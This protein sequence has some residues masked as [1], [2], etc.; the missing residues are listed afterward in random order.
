MSSIC[1]HLGSKAGG[2]AIFCRRRHECGKGFSVWPLHYW[3]CCC[4]VAKLYP[5]L[6]NPLDYSLPGSCVHGILQARILKQVAIPFFRAS[7]Q[8]RDWK[9][10]SCIAC[11][12]FTVKPPGKP[13]ICSNLCPLS[14]WCYL[15]ISSSAAR[16]PFAFNLTQ[17]QSFFQ[18]VGFLPQVAKVLELQPQSFQWIVRVDFL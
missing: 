14:Q 4:S 1:G 18:W 5:I 17:H 2:R 15:T 9:G 7:S 16:S 6:H 10:I 8:P 11:R 12:F 3:F 13:E